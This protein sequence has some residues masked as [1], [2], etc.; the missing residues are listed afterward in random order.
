MNGV[1]RGA[2]QSSLFGIL[3]LAALLFIPAWTLCFPKIPSDRI[4][5]MLDEQ[6]AI[7]HPLQVMRPG[8]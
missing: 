1:T 4:R 2:L 8:A 7:Q 5:E 6:H 3:V